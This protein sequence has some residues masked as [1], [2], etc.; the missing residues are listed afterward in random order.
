[1]EL[2]FGVNIA[3]PFAISANGG[4]MLSPVADRGREPGKEAA[5][6]SVPGNDEDFT[7]P[8]RAN[9][10]SAGERPFLRPFCGRLDKKE[11]A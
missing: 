10:P 6:A 2:F 3:T 8:W 4:E 5:A 9:M 7:D 11:G 1:L